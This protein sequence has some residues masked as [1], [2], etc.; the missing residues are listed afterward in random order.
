MNIDIEYIK[1]E[2]KKYYPV[3]ECP[4]DAD[5]LNKKKLMILLIMFYY[6]CNK[7][8]LKDIVKLLKIC[9]INQN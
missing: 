7:R 9:V 6:I 4:K 3:I 2:A 8:S 5:L 1:T